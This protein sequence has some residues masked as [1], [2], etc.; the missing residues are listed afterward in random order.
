MQ[1][2]F[3]A[4]VDFFLKKHTTYLQWSIYIG[5]IMSKQNLFRKKVKFSFIKFNR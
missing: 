1:A 4:E 3:V 2:G 5:L